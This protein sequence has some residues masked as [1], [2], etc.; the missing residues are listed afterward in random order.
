M[1]ASS[2]G[3]EEL[4]VITSVYLTWDFSTAVDNNLEAPSVLQNWPPQSTLPV[5]STSNT[6]LGCCILYTVYCF[7]IEIKVHFYPT[8][9]WNCFYYS[10]LSLI[11]FISIFQVWV[12]FI[13]VTLSSA[14]CHLSHPTQLGV[15]M[16]WVGF[17]GFSIQLSQT[18]LGWEIPNI[19]KLINMCR[20][21]PK[22][23]HNKLGRVGGLRLNVLCLVKIK[24]QFSST[25]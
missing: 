21:Q 13:F 16:A 10:L 24:K 1:A 14:K 12:Q 23:T 22:T 6:F 8:K 11:F 25:I 19:T 2:K 7:Y 9:V 15:C 18:L 4:V 17:E 3:N 5:F 20:N